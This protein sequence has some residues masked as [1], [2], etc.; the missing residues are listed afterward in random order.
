MILVVLVYC[1][2]HT[3]DTSGLLD[4][5]ACFF[6]IFNI[7]GCFLTRL[8]ITVRFQNLSLRNRGAFYFYFYFFFFLMAF[9][10]A[11]IT[12]LRRF[13]SSGVHGL[14]IS[15][16]L[17]LFTRAFSLLAPTSSAAGIRPTSQLRNYSTTELILVNTPYVSTKIIISESQTM[18][19]D[20]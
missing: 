5:K 16:C 18:I 2:E 8:V 15:S 12:E 14:L 6:G 4:S 3:C 10:A 19:G 11:L 9:W 17:M 20:V 7:R 1:P 13:T